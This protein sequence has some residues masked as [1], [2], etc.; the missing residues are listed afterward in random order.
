MTF[1]TFSLCQN[2]TKR[3]NQLFNQVS[4]RSYYKVKEQQEQIQTS[5]LL[6]HHNQDNNKLMNPGSIAPAFKFNLKYGSIF[7][8]YFIL[9]QI[10][11][12]IIS[13]IYYRQVISAE[14]TI[15]TIKFSQLNLMEKNCLVDEFLQGKINGT[16]YTSCLICDLARQLRNFTIECAYSRNIINE[17]LIQ[18]EKELRQIQ[19]DL[20]DYQEQKAENNNGNVIHSLKS[21]YSMSE[22]ELENKLYKKLVVNYAKQIDQDP[23][24]Q[25][26]AD[27]NHTLDTTIDD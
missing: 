16:N 23:S 18:C 22:R 11:S 14:P 26:Y 3:K 5:S 10:Y 1:C 25:S 4:R 8:L 24:I 20:I 19:S 12:I 6:L 27:K 7:K 13:V 17:S 15:K 9:I 21:D 2:L